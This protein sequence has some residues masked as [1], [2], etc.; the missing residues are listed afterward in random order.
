M[1]KSTD[2]GETWTQT[3]L[4][5]VYAAKHYPFL[6]R[7][8]NGKIYGLVSPRNKDGDAYWHGVMFMMSDDEGQT[9]KKADGTVYTLPVDD[10][11]A[12]WI[13][14][15]LDYMGW[16]VNVLPSGKPVALVFYD[17]STNPGDLY[18]Y[19]WN[20]TTWEQHYIDN[21]GN[22]RHSG[23]PAF[24]LIKVIDENTLEVYT[25]KDING[26]A[27]IVKYKTNDGGSTWSMEQITSNSSYPNARPEP[28]EPANNG[29]ADVI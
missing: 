12:D 24:G 4:V 29:V 27:E 7:K 22:L 14:K 19:K 16:D 3:K 26:V 28:V 20:G 5:E 25:T 18:L 21:I 17:S 13:I 11:Q 23:G 2:R 15:D 8:I 9:W 1:F 6:F 10:A